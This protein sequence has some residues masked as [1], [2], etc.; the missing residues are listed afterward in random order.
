MQRAHHDTTATR[1]TGSC[2]TALRSGTALSA[3]VWGGTAG[4][5]AAEAAPHPCAS[6]PHA[7]TGRPNRDGGDRVD[8][9]PVPGRSV[10]CTA[11]AN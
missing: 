7:C 3:R 6:S 10:G 2:T 5:P 9:K 11:T 1:G 4:L 8:D